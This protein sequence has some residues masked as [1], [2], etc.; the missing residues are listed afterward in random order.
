MLQEV[1]C[2]IGLV[3]LCSRS[4]I[5]PHTNSRSLCPRRVLSSNLNK[6]VAS[7]S[8]CKFI[9]TVNPL[10]NV[11]D[12]VLTPFFITGV[13]NPLFNGDTA[14][15]EARLRSPCERLRANRRDAIAGVRWGDE[16]GRI[17]R[18]MDVQVDVVPSDLSSSFQQPI[19]SAPNWIK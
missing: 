5:N 10:D 6:S 2:A 9:H 8:F 17:D 11:V 19:R 15:R 12:S 14:F 7:S 18:G 4:S 1:S 3:R 16:A 13:A